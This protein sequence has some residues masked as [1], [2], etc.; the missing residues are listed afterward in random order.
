LL[1]SGLILSVMAFVLFL[2]PAANAAPPANDD[3]DN[4]IT[5]TAVPVSISVDM[6]EATAAGDDPTTA[7]SPDAPFFTVWYA[8]TPP[9][10]MRLRMDVSFVETNFGVSVYTGSR[11]NLSEVVCDAGTDTRYFDVTAGTTYNFMV[12]SFAPVVMHFD[13][14]EILPPPS[15][16]LDINSKGSVNTTTGVATVRGTVTC[17]R[18]V[19]LEGVAVDL[20]QVFARRVTI[21]GGGTTDNVPCTPSGNTWSVVATGGNG[22]FGAGSA[23][24]TARTQ[25]CN[26]EGSCTLTSLTKSIRLR[27]AR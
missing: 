11:G 23:T 22:R 2:V 1:R 26:A 3:F 10:N 4:A 16:V 13:L 17:S 6:T 21:F 25:F 12:W 18:A 5:I 7:C 9:T 14:S 20:S 19:V 24:A 27:G 8:Y 15:V